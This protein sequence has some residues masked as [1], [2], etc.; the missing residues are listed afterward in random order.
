MNKKY[1]VMNQNKIQLN[2]VLKDYH[3]EIKHIRTLIHKIMLSSKNMILCSK[4]NDIIVKYNDYVVI[5]NKYFY[6]YTENIKAFQICNK[7][8]CDI[9]INNIVVSCKTIRCKIMDI[10]L[11]LS[12]LINDIFKH[13]DPLLMVAW[14]SEIDDEKQKHDYNQTYEY[15]TK[16]TKKARNIYVSIDVI[17]QN[18]LFKKCDRTNI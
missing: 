1:E 16:I 5:I 2:I 17:I 3:S 12:L 11:Y 4:L 9:I 14:L 7:R 15:L 10:Y 8:H 6:L 13:D 18:A